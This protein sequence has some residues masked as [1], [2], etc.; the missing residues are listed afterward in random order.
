MGTPPEVF[1]EAGY[2]AVHLRCVRARGKSRKRQSASNLRDTIL[3][4]LGPCE[5]C[6]Y[7]PAALELIEAYEQAL[8]EAWERIELCEI[9]KR[10][11]DA[12][13]RTLGLPPQWR[14]L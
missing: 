10:A 3:K 13:A 5:D 12:I 1:Q 4:R 8:R 14:M 9:R 6:R 11:D 2:E 7:D